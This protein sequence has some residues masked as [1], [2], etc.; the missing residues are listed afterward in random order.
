MFLFNVDTTSL[1][2]A[3]F[4]K[5]VMKYYVFFEKK[6]FTGTYHTK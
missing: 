1:L 2:G 5:N 6:Y 4:E 3:I